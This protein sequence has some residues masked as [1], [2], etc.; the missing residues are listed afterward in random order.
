MQTG[1]LAWARP[2]LGLPPRPVGKKPALEQ[3]LE[4]PTSVRHDALDQPGGVVPGTKQ[5][6]D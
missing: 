3:L 5:L 1:G 6:C 2:A 4:L